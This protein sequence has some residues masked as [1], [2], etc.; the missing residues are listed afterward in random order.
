MPQ[1]PVGHVAAVACAQRA[2]PRLVDEGIVLLGVVEAFHQVGERLPAPVAVH[3]IHKRL[4]VP[5]RSAHVDHDD[6]IAIG[7]EELGVPAIRPGVAPGPLGTA[8]NQELHWV[9]LRSIK[10]RRA[11]DESLNLGLVSGL[12][13]ERI[14]LG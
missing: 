6:D 7:G 11:D 4:P 8:V 9:F 13:P 5:R 2:L 10:P 14:H 1:H 12:E 3:A